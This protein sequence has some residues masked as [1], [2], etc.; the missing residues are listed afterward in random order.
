M[1]DSCSDDPEDPGRRDEGSNW[2]RRP[3]EPESR[4]DTSSYTI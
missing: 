1:E 4:V 2:R 3:N